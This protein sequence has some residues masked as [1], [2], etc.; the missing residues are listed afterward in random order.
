MDFRN[1]HG[2]SIANCRG[3]GYDNGSNMAGVYKGIQANILAVNS[4]AFYSPC[5]CQSLNFCGYHAAESSPEVQKFLGVVQKLYN[6]FSSSPMRWEILLANIGQSLHSLAHTWWSDRVDSVRPFAAHIPGFLASLDE[7]LKLNLSPEAKTDVHAFQSYV[8][9]FNCIFLAGIWITVLSAIDLHNKVLQA[10]NATLDVEVSNIESLIDELK[11]LRK[12]WKQIFSEAKTVAIQFGISAAF[13]NERKTRR[14]RFYDEISDE[15][16]TEKSEETAFQHNVY[17]VLLDSV[18]SG[19][20]VR[21][22]AVC[23]INGLIIFFSLAI[24]DHAR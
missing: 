2:I 11:D 10:R 17:N 24:H 13:P 21:Y 6:F 9:S 3:Q 23:E 16:S 7:V 20:R 5:A 15:E 8:G 1:K 14:K 4:L 22:K 18:I 12:Q 19:L